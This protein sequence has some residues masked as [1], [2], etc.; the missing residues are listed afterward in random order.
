MGSAYAVD[1]FVRRS[2]EMHKRKARTYVSN[3]P[4]RFANSQ[5]ELAQK[6]V[7]LPFQVNGVCGELCVDRL[8]PK[9]GR[10]TPILLGLPEL[11][12]MGCKSDFEKMA[13]SCT[14]LDVVDEP[15]TLDDRG[16]MVIN[17][18]PDEPTKVNAV[19]CFMADAFPGE[20]VVPGRN[21]R[22]R[23]DSLVE[24]NIRSAKRRKQQHSEISSSSGD[25]SHDDVDE[26]DSSGD[27]LP[28]L[29]EDTTIEKLK[30]E[31]RVVPFELLD[32]FDGFNLDYLRRLAGTR[33][34]LKKLHCNLGH[35][36]DKV[37]M[38]LKAAKLPPDIVKAY[39][40]ITEQCPSCRNYA[41]KPRIPRALGH[42]AT[43]VN[44]FVGM[45]IIET[46]IALSDGT[47]VKPRWLHFVDYFS[48]FQK[49]YRI[50]EYT[51]QECSA[52]LLDFWSLMGGPMHN[53]VRDNEP[54]FLNIMS[55]WL[56]RYDVTEHP[57]GR[58]SPH[59]N[60]I[61]ENHGGY[62][63]SIFFRTWDE[64][65]GLDEFHDVTPD[66]VMSACEISKNAF[67]SRCG[68]PPCRVA[69]G[70]DPT[71][72]TSTFDE[73]RVRLEDPRK[74]GEFVHL[75]E[76]V[77]K[78]AQRHVLA[79]ASSRAIKDAILKRAFRSDG[80][81]EFK[82]GNHV[83]FWEYGPSK[84]ESGWVGRGIVTAVRGKVLSINRSNGKTADIDAAF[85]RLYVPPRGVD[86]LA[87]LSHG[88]DVSPGDVPDDDIDDRQNRI[89]DAEIES[90]QRRGRVW[91][92]RIQFENQSKIWQTAQVLFNLR[93]IGKS[94]L[95]SG[96]VTMGHQ[97]VN[98][99]VQPIVDRNATRTARMDEGFEI[100]S[101]LFQNT[102]GNDL[103]VPHQIRLTKVGANVPIKRLDRIQ[104][105]HVLEMKENEPFRWSEWTTGDSVWVPEDASVVVV[106]TWFPT[107]QLTTDVDT[108][109]V[110]EWLD[111]KIAEDS[112]IF[113]QLLA[114]LSTKHEPE[115]ENAR[116]KRVDAA[117]SRLVSDVNTFNVINRKRKLH[118]KWQ[119]RRGKADDRSSSDRPCPVYLCCDESGRDLLPMS[120]DYGSEGLCEFDSYLAYCKED[121]NSSKTVY[122]PDRQERF[123]DRDS[124]FENVFYVSGS[125]L[126]IDE[127]TSFY[128]SEIA[129]GRI[130][131]Q[132][133][134]EESFIAMREVKSKEIPHHLAVGEM[135]DLSMQRELNSWRDHE[136][137]RVV[138][139]KELEEAQIRPITTRWVF[140]RKDDKTGPESFKSRLA[141]RGFQ[142]QT[143]GGDVDSPT[144][145]RDSF[146]IQLALAANFGWDLDVAD[147]PTAF[148]R[149]DKQLFKRKVYLKPPNKGMNMCPSE[150]KPGKNEIWRCV[151]PVYG[152]NDAPRLWYETAVAK[153]LA[154]GLT[155]CTWDPCVFY[156][157]NKS[158][159]LDGLLILHVD[160][161][162]ATGSPEFL[163]FCSEMLG[164]LGVKKFKRVGKEPVKY[165]GIEVQRLSDGRLIAQQFKYHEMLSLIDVPKSRLNEMRLTP[166]EVGSARS[167]LG[168]LAWLSTQTRPD[169][170]LV[171]SGLVG[172][173]AEA[174]EPRVPLL[175]K[176]NAV[177]ELVKSKPFA[178]TFCKH[179]I[180]LE[181]LGI[182][183]F[184]DSSW[185]SMPGL[186]S[187]EGVIC[188]MTDNRISEECVKRAGSSNVQ[189]R[190]TATSKIKLPL[191]LLSWKSC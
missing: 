111:D 128:A 30:P 175:R 81:F 165:C 67:P 86:P 41:S 26:S 42:V 1:R 43:F 146:R 61:A 12:S 98:G 84:A 46:P 168:A 91:R 138:D 15:I 9:P 119:R 92:R 66:E 149:A 44:E 183:C 74:F 113:E 77:H 161:T 32:R 190:G 150:I 103:G 89:E 166:D 101:N 184:Q 120:A 58:D 18:L 124:G 164:K 48:R 129:R 51:S 182:A 85:A 80:H 31:N 106:F 147:V 122:G 60:P 28:I 72:L 8:S 116:S 7:A 110:D 20:V 17:L 82:V 23:R 170:A 83:E 118:P 56:T 151:T 38:L 107:T 96:M 50:H 114:S 142:D 27:D 40:E 187:Q 109:V 191:S 157:R 126:E 185:A 59:Q 37:V 33:S 76:T 68:M 159:K 155:R 125:I 186:R 64:L 153:F 97:R 22:T 133:Q 140:T 70:R 39:R 174:Q 188:V 123:S 78:I 87:G 178:I 160:D 73:D 21:I 158:G 34:G 130:E 112:V 13:W 179:G 181:H 135:W 6:G 99:V 35:N 65:M 29:P 95:S 25:S 117:F 49:A 131:V 145:G 143:L 148:L 115:L 177:V 189:L 16:H 169:L 47:R 154:A 172:W 173:L 2:V 176:I 36:R 167:V 62:L 4:Y 108:F 11:K 104:S 134:V 55:R 57:T 93:G 100:F 121:A 53:L 156:R 79:V 94:A 105:C 144:A 139:S 63:K 52:A 136:C 45:D 127:M 14:K 54:G 19:Q 71:F 69:F 171:V 75:K 24:A 162:S 132:C 5:V 3:A 102:I 180:P 88:G 141:A 152:L 163:K 137:V 90:D 10:Q